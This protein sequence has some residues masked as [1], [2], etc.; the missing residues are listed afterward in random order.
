MIGL[1]GGAFGGALMSGAG[2]GIIFDWAMLDWVAP[3]AD[4]GA[5]G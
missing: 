3:Q 5:K 2:I 1:T 4:F